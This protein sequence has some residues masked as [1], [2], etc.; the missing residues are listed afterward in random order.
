MV[1][2]KYKTLALVGAILSAQVVDCH[3]HHEGEQIPLSQ[4]EL[5]HKWAPELSA[6]ATM[7]SFG[8]LKH[9]PCLTKP[10]ELYDIAIIGAPFDTATSYRPGA[11]FGPRAIRE[12]SG[13]QVAARSY[14]VRAGINPYL[15]WAKVIDCG[16]IPITQMD[17][18]IAERQMFEAFLELGMRK[19][20]YQAQEKGDK[21]KRQARISDGKPKLVTL[22]GDHSII[23]PALRALNQIY[24]K[25]IT[26]IHFDAHQDTWESSRY[27]GYWK[28]DVDGLNHGT[29]LFHAGQEGLISNTTSAH[30]GLRSYLGGSDDRDYRTGVEKGFM[31][32][33]ADDVDDIGTQGVVDAIVSRVGLDP[34]QPVYISLDI[35]VLDPSIAPGTGTP[36]SGGWTS[37]ELARILRGLEKLNVV[38]ADVVEVSPSYDHRAGGTALAAA[39]VVN[40]I[41]A[42]MVKLGVE[43]PDTVGGWF[44]RKGNKPVK[45]G[46]MESY[47]EGAAADT[48]A[49]K[50][51]L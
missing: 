37:R 28:P 27:D 50:D 16:N 22:G 6:F 7:G 9:V 44:G 39:H 47:Q 24:K 40:E 23:L 26:V 18:R 41:I 35:D 21:A 1:C 12:A 33:H 11:R 10:N 25:P 14:N 29:W 2:L 19:T 15:D 45:E 49:R 5:E 4:E 34:D 36:E 13:R 46:V 43:D 8:G 20:A 17:N 51:E 38:G 31:R 3:S 48:K 32:I 42:S 30:A